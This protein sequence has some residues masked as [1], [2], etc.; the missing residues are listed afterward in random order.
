[1]LTCTIHH[2]GGQVR[3]ADSSRIGQRAH[4]WRWVLHTYSLNQSQHEIHICCILYRWTS[5]D[6]RQQLNWSE[7]TLMTAVSTTRIRM[8]GATSTAWLTAPQSTQA[9][10]PTSRLS[11]R[12]SCDTS[13]CLDV[14]TP[15]VTISRRFTLPCYRHISSRR[16]LHAARVVII[17]CTM[18]RFSL[19]SY[20]Y[21]L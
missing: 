12:G 13:L 14:R 9:L 7:S 4:W 17:I 11:A 8:R 2:T 10:P 19:W 5:Q 18:K 3:A 16:R 20:C 15:R 21:L 1:M 6:S